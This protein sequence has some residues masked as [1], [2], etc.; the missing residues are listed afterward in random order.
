MSDF[1]ELKYFLLIVG[2]SRSGSTLVG[3]IIDAHPCAIIANETRASAVFWN[4]LGRQ[5]ILQEILINSDQNRAAGNLS[6]GYS[7]A[8]KGISLKQNQAITVMGD[9]VWNPATLLMHGDYS[10]LPRI[11]Q[12]IGVPVKI[13][14]AIRNPF[15][16]IATMHTRSGAAVSDRIR[17]HFMHCDAMSAI[18]NR[19]RRPHSMDIHH[20]DLIESPD[21]VITALCDFL[22]LNPDPEYITACKDRIFSKPKKTRSDIIWN[23]KDKANITV[24]MSQHDFLSRYLAR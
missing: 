10:L 16:V 6:E 9:K 15:D 11:E 24:R 21:N 1:K 7:Y 14:H 3:A 19:W 4:G 23:N 20:E 8:I 12:L 5:A 18:R 17:W 2:S 13:I 22:E